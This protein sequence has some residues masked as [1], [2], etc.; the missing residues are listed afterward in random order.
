MAFLDLRTILIGYIGG[1]LICAIVLFTLWRENRSRYTGLE[2]WMGSF[3]FNFIGIALLAGR[4]TIPD[5]LSVMI[6]SVTLVMGTFTLYHGLEIFLRNRGAPLHLYFLL[7]IYIILQA[8][9]VYFSPNLLARNI[10]FSLTLIFFSIQ[11]AWLLFWRIDPE[12]QK[13]TRNLG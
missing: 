10:L 7:G 13:I 3:I 12:T 9:F 5:F 2:F 1:N 4:G 6:G 11:F 8:Y